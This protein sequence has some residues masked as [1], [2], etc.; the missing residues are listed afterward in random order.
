MPR[1]YH[2]QLYSAAAPHPW[3][4]NSFNASRPREVEWS[5]PLARLKPSLLGPERQE[6][7]TVETQQEKQSERTE[8]TPTRKPGENQAQDQSRTARKNA[9]ATE[10]QQKIH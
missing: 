2:I 8:S 5:G 6:V 4:R 3:V 1:F 7:R 9:T 10:A